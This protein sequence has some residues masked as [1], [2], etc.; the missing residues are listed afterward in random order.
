MTL[1]RALLLVAMAALGGCS[2]GHAPPPGTAI[3]DIRAIE[4][5][6]SYSGWDRVDEVHRLQPGPGRRGFVRRSPPPTATD[7]QASTDSVPAQRV[8]EL[9]WAVDAPAWNQQRAATEMA[10][11][12]RPA[13]VLKHAP[14]AASDT[15]PTCT[16]ARIQ[17]YLQ[18]MLGVTALR[19]RLDAYYAGGVWTDDDPV[20]SVRIEYE[21]APAQVLA[22]R[23]QKLMMLPWT[24]GEAP[25][26]GADAP[27]SY[28]LPISQA[29][30]RLLPDT[31]RAVARLTAREDDYLLD[32]LARDART[33]CEA[34]QR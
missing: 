7:G 32:V 4:I 9:L 25:A 23:S 22:S 27:R 14:I 30:R 29:V 12:V 13:Q 18:P 28:S 19:R 5:R 31:S 24:V 6:Y 26:G 8:A 21:T 33:A 1:R 2:G 17:G 16:I 3:Q 15:V 10:R 11:R 34:A 20:I